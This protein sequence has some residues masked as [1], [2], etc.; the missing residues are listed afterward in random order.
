MFELLPYGATIDLKCTSC[1]KKGELIS[2]YISSTNYITD[3][4]EIGKNN[5]YFL[6]SSQGPTTMTFTYTKKN[7]I[8]V[9]IDT[10]LTIVD[11]NF[12]ADGSGS[13][14]I[15]NENF[16]P[17]GSDKPQGDTIVN[18]ERVVQEHNGRGY[19]IIDNNSFPS[20]IYGTVYRWEFRDVSTDR[21]IVEDER[22]GNYY[23][24][25]SYKEV[26]IAVY[27]SNAPSGAFR[28][29]TLQGIDTYYYISINNSINIEKLLDENKNIIPINL[30]TIESSMIKI[31]SSYKN[32]TITIVYNY[33]ES[34][35]IDEKVPYI[36]LLFNKVNIE[37]CFVNVDGLGTYSQNGWNDLKIVG[38]N[39]E[40][41][42]PGSYSAQNYCKLQRYITVSWSTEETNQ[43][44]IDQL[45]NNGHWYQAFFD[46]Y[47]NNEVPIGFGYGTSHRL[48]SVDQSVNTENNKI[49]SK[50]TIPPLNG[51]GQLNNITINKY[52]KIGYS[53]NF[54]GEGE[55]KSAS[56]L[57]INGNYYSYD[58]S[59]IFK[60][61][62][63]SEQI[64]SN[65]SSPLLEFHPKKNIWG[66]N[67]KFYKTN[68]GKY[69]SPA[70]GI[71]I[72]SV[73]D[74]TNYCIPYNSCD[75][76][77]QTPC[78]CESPCDSQCEETQHYI[79]NCSGK[80]YYND[81]GNGQPDL[82]AG[83]AGR[84]SGNDRMKLTNVYGHPSG[85]YYQGDNGPW[86]H[87]GNVN[88]D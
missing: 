22:I 55:W 58:S 25:N 9:G 64:N 27:C 53:I 49:S 43:L 82:S 48:W 74:T 17:S 79:Y 8:L 34:G 1:S 7:G 44:M 47:D 61:E 51:T 56:A 2:E 66:S 42:Q 67:S 35:I 63:I 75:C 76:D 18:I 31:D 30:Y 84:W 40:I 10:N 12:G 20:Y 50:I 80:Y 5:C 72:N 86:F 15:T 46:T 83:A 33:G 4:K 13:F 77:C 38:S 26:I 57:N 6:E 52:F 78:D 29:V 41:L 70:N 68:S 60:F 37:C 11:S 85:S 24:F 21:V 32:K 69:I 73:W 88:V 81:N 65:N 36:K 59:G 54:H 14:T 16:Y 62:N 87:N 19:V 3:F 39:N 28:R 71:I 23:Y 45:K